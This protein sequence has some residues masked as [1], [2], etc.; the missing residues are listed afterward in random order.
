MNEKINILCAEDH[1]PLAK[2][3]Q[4]SLENAG[5]KVHVVHS[6][7]QVLEKAK[8]INPSLFLLDL[9]MPKMDGFQILSA[10]RKEEAFRNTPVVMMTAMTKA[11]EHASFKEHKIFDLIVKPF[12]NEHLV[13]RVHSA[14]NQLRHPCS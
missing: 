12:R 14:L 13:E 4:I 10:L 9:M 1:R 11:S 3:I 5:Y 6:G 7:E 2:V 8:E